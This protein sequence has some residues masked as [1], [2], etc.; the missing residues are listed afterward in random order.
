[1]DR[2][3]VMNGKKE[4]EMPKQG[5][6]LKHEKG[7][8]Y[9]VDFHF[10]KKRSALLVIDLQNDFF[11]D[12]GVHHKNGVDVKALR[13]KIPQCVR[14]SNFCREAGIPII[15]IR[16][17]LHP[18]QSGKAADAGLFIEGARPWL[19]H[20]GLR[21][22]SWGAQMLDELGKPD[23]DVEKNRASGFFGTY[24]ET[25]LRGIRIDTLIFSGFATN[26][27]VENTY[28]DAWVRDFRVIGIKDAMITHDPFLQ[29]ASEKNMDIMGHCLS[30]D[31][32]QRI[33]EEAKD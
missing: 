21:P 9:N 2:M 13:P 18:D 27:C 3:G 11:H 4:L 24:L 28:R 19:V 33:L 29:E 31:D 14:L 17:I 7:K 25:L 30:L 1:M 16:Y 22:G 15:H 6:S 20:E 26:I 10:D 23:F 8:Y 32:F 12:D 5:T